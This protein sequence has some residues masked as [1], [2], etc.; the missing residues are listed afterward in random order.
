MMSRGKVKGPDG[1]ISDCGKDVYEDHMGNKVFCSP[2]KSDQETRFSQALQMLK[3][4]VS[5]R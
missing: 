4:G 2:L 5:D 3:A 1:Q